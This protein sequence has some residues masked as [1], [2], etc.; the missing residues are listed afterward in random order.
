[1]R[2][3]IYRLNF[4]ARANRQLQ[5]RGLA[6]MRIDLVADDRVGTVFDALIEAG[7]R[8]A[9]VRVHPAQC[10]KGGDAPVGRM[11]KRQYLGPALHLARLAGVPLSINV[12]DGNSPSLARFAFSGRPDRVGLLPD[13]FFFRDNGYAAQHDLATREGK[14]WAERSGRLVWRGRANGMGHYS[15]HPGD[16]DNP[17][18]IHR[19][20][21]LHAA[22][23]LGIDAGIVPMPSGSDRRLLEVGGFLADRVPLADWAGLKYAIDI[24]GFSNAWDNLA[25]RLILGCCVLKVA[26]P[27]G[28]AQWYYDRLRPWEHYVPVATDL[29]D[30]AARIDWLHQNDDKAQAIAAAGQAVMRKLTFDSEMAWAAARIREAA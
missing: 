21:F 7:A 24:D 26:S 20:H 19:L 11:M 29:S 13:P 28:F 1:M 3:L 5:A 18:L 17:R 23:D 12:S 10:A 30:L 25:H 4:Q 2:W 22:R 8:R 6:P 15:L 14:P 16:R 27:F 9:V